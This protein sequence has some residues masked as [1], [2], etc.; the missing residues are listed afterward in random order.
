M[1]VLRTCPDAFQIIPE[2]PEHEK[3]QLAFLPRS[4]SSI[5]SVGYKKLSFMRATENTSFDY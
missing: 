4:N 1:N 2:N 3:K 5:F